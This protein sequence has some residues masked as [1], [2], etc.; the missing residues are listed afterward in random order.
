MSVSV[1]W[2]WG[3]PI[4]RPLSAPRL[5]RGGA[6]RAWAELASPPGQEG[7]RGRQ[8]RQTDRR[9]TEPEKQEDT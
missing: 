3:V 7:N 4:P 5:Q 2:G 8:G 1:S 9:E 6:G